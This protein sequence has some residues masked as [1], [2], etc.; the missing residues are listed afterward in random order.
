MENPLPPSSYA[1]IADD[2]LLMMMNK[3]VERA[4]SAELASTRLKVWLAQQCLPARDRDSVQGGEPSTPAVKPD[5]PTPQPFRRNEQVAMGA[6]VARQASTPPVGGRIRMTRNEAA[7]Y[8]GRSR[9]TLANWAY[10]RV[11]P[12]YYKKGGVHYFKD[13]LDSWQ[14]TPA[15]EGE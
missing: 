2:E 14:A 12:P 1:W 7:A 4:P 6:E 10:E 5:K 9:S 13:E 8:L 3:Y 11:G 15:F